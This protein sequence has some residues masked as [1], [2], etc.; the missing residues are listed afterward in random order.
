MTN[1]SM[2]AAI[3]GAAESD[4]IG[5]A[6]SEK[7]T[8]NTQLHIEAISN[9]CE[10]TGISPDEIEGVFSAGFTPQIAEYLNIR[11]KYLDHTGIG[12]SSFELH[13]HHALAAI[14][15]GVIDVALVSHGE[16]GRSA[17]KNQGR[18]TGG[19]G[20]GDPWA[21]GAAFSGGPYG[22]WGAPY[23]YSHAMT[24]HMHQFGSTKEDFAQIAVS[25]RDW[26]TLNP[27][28]VMHSKETDPNG[29]PITVQDVLDSRLISWPL[30]ILD[31]CLVTDH[32]GAVLLASAEKAH[33][34]KT[35]PVWV[36]GAG[37][38]M[39]HWDMLEMDDF[40]LTSAVNSG[41]TAYQM[42][43]MGPSEMELGMIYDSFTV[44]VGIT[45]ESLGLAPRGGF[46]ELFEGGKAGPG[47]S[48]MPINTNGGGLSFSHSG[49]YGMMLLVEAYRQLS[50]TAE[51]GIH[52]IAG[53]QTSAQSA[54]VNGTGGS[55]STTGTLILT[56]DQ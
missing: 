32:G 56:S 52:G 12:G 26:A 36:A 1:P 37:E 41:K 34:F 22:G 31:V 53:K 50:G 6:L 54:I 46:M 4:E 9:V 44:T 24:R 14:A 33:S 13:V 25:T 10:Q 20:R 8:T 15:A 43:G 21:P 2:A 45:V 3:V 11:P 17:R 30:N 19:G 42:A 51:D 27:R 40:T 23:N 48:G 18:G 16:S 7:G 55:L 5:F 29:G 35:P 47:G 28:A 49:M 39:G 38:S